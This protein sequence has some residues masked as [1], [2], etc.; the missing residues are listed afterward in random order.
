[1]LALKDFQKE[2]FAD[3]LKRPVFCQKQGHE[4]KKLEFFYKRCEVVICSSCVA[5]THEAHAKIIL[6]EASKECELQI[7]CYVESNK[8]FNRRR[9]T[10]LNLTKT[11][12]KFKFRLP[13]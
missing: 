9:A 12:I 11:A 6:E 8:R 1:M 2:D 3:I 4:K 13:M 7:K 10:S 5:T